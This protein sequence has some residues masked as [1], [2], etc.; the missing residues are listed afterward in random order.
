MRVTAQLVDTASGAHLWAEHYDRDLADI[1]AILAHRRIVAVLRLKLS[2]VE[3]KRLGR[4]GT[5]SLEAHD[6]LLR[7]LTRFWDYTRES[8]EEAQAFFSRALELDPGYAT[9][10]AWLARTLAF[11]WTQLW[12]PAD[13]TLDRAFEHARAAVSLDEDL[14]FALSVLGWVHLWRKEPE[15]AIAAGWRAV[16]I[17][18]N[19]ADAHHFL[20]LSLSSVGRGEEALHYTETALRLN[21]F[22]SAFYMFAL[23]SALF[24]LEQYDKAIAAFGRGVELTEVFAPN[25][26]FLCL[27]YTLLGREEEARL[28]RDRLLALTGGRTPVVQRIMIDEELRQ[29]INDLEK[30]AGLAGET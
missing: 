16:A 28:E 22:P 1:F 26:Y 7:G 12:D 24:V 6:C 15:A 23:G 4:A 25:H 10:H 14:P 18:P 8:S 29:R 27:T 17:D 19:N 5:A 30:L 21:P 9:A 20:S 13:E 11:R 3:R 2:G